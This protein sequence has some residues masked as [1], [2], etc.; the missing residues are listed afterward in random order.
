[1]RV[2]TDVQVRG[3][4]AQLNGRIGKVES[5]VQMVEQVL[6]SADQQQEGLGVPQQ[7]PQANSVNL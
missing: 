7:R 4:L 3:R 5:K 1:M 6:F 2:P